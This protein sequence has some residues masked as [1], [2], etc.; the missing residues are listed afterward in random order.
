MKTCCGLICTKTQ[1][2]NRGV[3]IHLRYSPN[4]VFLNEGIVITYPKL[5]NWFTKKRRRKRLQI[6]V[7]ICRNLTLAAN[8]KP[9][10]TTNTLRCTF[11][12]LKCLLYLL[13]IDES[14][15]DTK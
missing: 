14:K 6:H 5:F 13:F 1:N 2:I 15:N 3:Y 11:Q 7:L 8:L 4:I 10:M 9:K 12:N